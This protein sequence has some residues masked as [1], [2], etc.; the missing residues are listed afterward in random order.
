MRE[1]KRRSHLAL[2]LMRFEGACKED[3][4]HA[5]AFVENSGIERVLL[6]IVYPRQADCFQTETN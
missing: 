1:A 6:S 2:S 4:S 3:P 5:C